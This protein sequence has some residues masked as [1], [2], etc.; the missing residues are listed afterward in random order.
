VI[1]E[2]EETVART[3]RVCA[4]DFHCA[5]V[6]SRKVCGRDDCAKPR[7]PTPPKL[8][9]QV[10][11]AR[12][13]ATFNKTCGQCGAGF[14]TC[15][16]YQKLCSKA[17][18]RKY[19]TDAQREARAQRAEPVFAN[20][21]ICGTRFDKTWYPTKKLCGS[22]ACKKR[23]A[24][25]KTREWYAANRPARNCAFCDKAF[26]W[27]E[28]RR[29]C[30]STEC[31]L[32]D[33]TRTLEAAEAAKR[34]AYARKIQPLR[35]FLT[36]T[37]VPAADFGMSRSQIHSL[38]EVRFAG[39]YTELDV[40]AA[41]KGSF[42]KHRGDKGVRYLVAPSDYVRPLSVEVEPAPNEPTQT[43]Y[44]ID[45]VICGASFVCNRKYQLTCG[46]ACSK[47]RHRQSVDRWQKAQRTFMAEVRDLR[48]TWL[49][50]D[51]AAE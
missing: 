44:P 51:V 22:D 7:K 21:D 47:V 18:V 9:K 38:V 27:S 12:Q 19:N 24:I 14:T 3:C 23:A 2:I 33:S 11:P 28:A 26:E 42:Q 5:G 39:V 1:A 15:R 37:L 31:D 50:E 34:E 8:E 17:C 35:L 45:C 49:E 16:A 29:R 32:A 43:V 4:R 6:S 46:P 10:R 41:M 13:P 36:E 25:L 30:C 20:C 48:E 40:S